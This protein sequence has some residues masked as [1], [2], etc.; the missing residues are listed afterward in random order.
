MVNLNLDKHLTRGCVSNASEVTE[1]PLQEESLFNSS[2]L[3]HCF[4]QT[5]S[6]DSISIFSRA[7]DTALDQMLKSEILHKDTRE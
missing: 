4:C 6:N 1:V 2:S 7:V 5:A 3:E